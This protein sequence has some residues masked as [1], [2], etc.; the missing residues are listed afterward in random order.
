MDLVTGMTYSNLQGTFSQT[1]YFRSLCIIFYIL[2]LP[3][4]GVVGRDTML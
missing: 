4:G 1:R 2:F 3:R